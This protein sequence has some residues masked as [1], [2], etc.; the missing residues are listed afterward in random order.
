MNTEGFQFT[1]EFFRK[2][3]PY[4]VNIFERQFNDLSG[5]LRIAGDKFAVLSVPGLYHVKTGL[6]TEDEGGNAMMS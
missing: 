6:A 1:K 3:G 5:S 4:C 2:A